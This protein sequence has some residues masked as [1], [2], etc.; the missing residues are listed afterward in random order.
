[1]LAALSLNYTDWSSILI[2][3]DFIAL[4]TRS[5]D[6][7]NVARLEMTMSPTPI[8]YT[9]LD[10]SRALWKTSVNWMR[11]AFNLE[12]PPEQ[13]PPGFGKASKSIGRST[14]NDEPRAS[15]GT[16]PQWPTGLPQAS[17]EYAK[18]SQAFKKSVAR[19]MK[20]SVSVEPPRG[21]I[22][23]SGFVELLGPKG[24]CLFDVRAAYAPTDSE[25]AAISLDVRR[26]QLR[27]Q[28]PKG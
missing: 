23:L 8:L 22:L 28:R 4:V 27:E 18:A 6:P 2:T 12:I 24:I 20:R 1:M 26:L 7:M 11:R 25:W 3:D 19:N 14:T 5:V 16:Q 17:Q 9:L 13:L 10:N 21:T 15:S